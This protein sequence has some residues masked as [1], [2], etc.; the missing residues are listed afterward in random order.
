[1]NNAQTA[2]SLASL[3][4][5]GDSMLVHMTPREVGGLQAL[6][7]NHGLSLT[8]NPETGLPEAE[9]LDFILPAIAG[10]ALGP[11]GFGIMGSLGAAATVGVA[12][13]LLTGDLSKGLTAGLSAFG[14]STLG[15]AL[16][17]MGSAGASTVADPVT[18]TLFNQQ[19]T[20]AGTNLGLNAT[21]AE[22]A[23]N[24]IVP[25]F[26]SLG[27][28]AT[29]PAAQIALSNAGG[30][31]FTT[32]GLT[33]S[34]STALSSGLFNAPAAAS[35]PISSGI[36]SAGLYQGPAMGFMD[37]FK[38]AATSGGLGK[39]GLPLAIAGL[40]APLLGGLTSP[41]SAMP[42][43]EGS[44]Y[45]GPYLPAP[46]QVRFPG[47]RGN[48]S[49]EFQYFD[50]VSP[51]PG[52]IKAASGGEMQILTVVPQGRPNVDYEALY[53]RFLPPPRPSVASTSASSLPASSP[54]VASDIPTKEVDYKIEALKP[55][56]PEPAPTPAANQNFLRNDFVPAWMFQHQ[57]IG[58]WSNPGFYRNPS[59]YGYNGSFS[60]GGLA[61]LPLENGSFILDA[62]TVSEIGNG[63]SRAGQEI[64]GKLGG[65][66]IQGSGDG[67]SDS[68]H[69][70]I[71]GVQK[72]KVARDEVKFSPEVVSKLGGGDHKKGAAK[73][74]DLMER[75]EKARRSA[76]R[77]EDS[78]LKKLMR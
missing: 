38:S 62:R 3:G 64:L 22:A 12:T 70:K 41:S 55:V 65:V 48:D 42:A 25:N 1:M 44:D 19:N 14:G 50:N 60:S 34:G 8:V 54:P 45:D 4:R 37:A 43:T 73:L 61:E 9:I 15:S 63:S 39:L 26:A 72:A 51:Y 27:G 47:D 68:I 30:I 24:S 29:A 40:S 16:K 17:G 75:A 78:G 46:R 7:Q 35:A 33:S 31:P 59:L 77:G 5:N 20:L 23:K 57:G 66:P 6:A 53:N 13:G 49:S 21:A 2:Q 28:N 56:E 36:S 11:A 32:S 67:V 18:S 52:Y 74:Y 10:F 71:G 76:E 58:P 69:A